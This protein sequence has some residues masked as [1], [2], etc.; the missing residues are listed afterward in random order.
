MLPP[1]NYGDQTQHPDLIQETK[2]D[3]YWSAIENN[4]PIE[5]V[6][7]DVLIELVSLITGDYEITERKI[8][9]IAKKQKEYCNQ[10]DIR[11]WVIP[12]L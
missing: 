7:P 9:E 6:H 1:L 10:N 2:A 4:K 3:S 5:T 11:D 8:Y 12:N